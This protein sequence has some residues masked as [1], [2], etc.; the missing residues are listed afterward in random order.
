MDR[1]AW[2]ATVHVVTESDRTERLTRSLSISLL[3]SSPLWWKN[4][5]SLDPIGKNLSPDSPV[6]LAPKEWERMYV[7]CGSRGRWGLSYYSLWTSEAGGRTF[8]LFS[9][10]KNKELHLCESVRREPKMFPLHDSFILWT[11]Q[12]HS[13]QILYSLPFPDR[14]E[15]KGLILFKAKIS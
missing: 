11:V 4:T 5:S 6:L 10:Y 1:G 3:P 14:Q 8:M 12:I 2:W 9:D 7:Y 13:L 15:C